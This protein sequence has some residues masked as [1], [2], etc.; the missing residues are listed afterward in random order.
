MPVPPM[1]YTEP[2]KMPVSDDLDV[3]QRC[4]PAST[5]DAR[6]HS[7]HGSSLRRLIVDGAIIAVPD[8]PMTIS[9]S[10]AVVL[11]RAGERDVRVPVRAR[12]R[13]RPGRGLRGVLP[14]EKGLVE[15]GDHAL[16]PVEAAGVLA[17]LLR[18]Q[19]VRAGDR[20]EDAGDAAGDDVR[21][22]LGDDGRA[23]HAD[24]ADEDQDRAQ[25]QQDPA[26]HRT[27][28]LAHPPPE[29]RR[30]GKLV[31]E[32][33]LRLRFHDDPPRRGSQRTARVV[34]R[35]AGSIHRGAMQ[36]PSVPSVNAR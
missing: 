10:G 35:R 4:Q 19:E 13:F 23:G 27:G 3:V 16:E 29:Q 7:G 20:E 8:L 5:S 2:A 25:P 22:L 15:L 31:V 18:A 26:D 24:P 6:S 9:Q 1:A 17:E 32:R 12:L 33:T 30:V 11:P 14:C 34:G 28:G 36:I 21:D